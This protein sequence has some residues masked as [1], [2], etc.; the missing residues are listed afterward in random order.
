MG[1]RQSGIKGAPAEEGSVREAGQVAQAGPGQ[2]GRG[3]AGRHLT[4]VA[5]LYVEAD[6]R[7]ILIILDYEGLITV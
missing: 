4:D 2:G 3:E 1:A 6:I 7:L 5:A